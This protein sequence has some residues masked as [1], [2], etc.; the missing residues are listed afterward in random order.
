MNSEMTMSFMA[1]PMVKTRQQCM[2]KS[3]LTADDLT[4]ESDCTMQGYQMS[5]TQMTFTMIC[6][7]PEGPTTA[8]GNYI[9]EGNSRHG[10][11][12]ISMMMN[13]AEQT[14]KMVWTGRRTG[15]C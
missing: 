14:M 11:T 3:E 1:Q 12:N 8:Q 6:P 2:E 9:S 15:N 7:G 4:V 5:G 10:E 13:G